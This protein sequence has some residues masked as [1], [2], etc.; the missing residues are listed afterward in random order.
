MYASFLGISEAPAPRTGSATERDFA[1]LNLHMDIFHQPIRSQ[2]FDSIICIPHF[3][4][5]PS[6]HMLWKAKVG[7]ESISDVSNALKW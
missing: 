5:L 2:F 6:Q 4:S 1:R 3:L 7:L